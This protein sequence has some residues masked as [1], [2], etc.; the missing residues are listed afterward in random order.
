MLTYVSPARIS[1]RSESP[2][3]VVDKVVDEFNVTV[4]DTEP[5]VAVLRPTNVTPVPGDC[6]GSKFRSTPAD[7][8]VGF[9]GS[10]NGP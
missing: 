8:D 5:A 4:P 3:T 10:G 1:F 2:F 6:V 7:V 9:E